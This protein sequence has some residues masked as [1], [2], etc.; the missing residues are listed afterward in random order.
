MDSYDSNTEKSSI[1]LEL[2]RM[3]L[4]LDDSEIIEPGQEVDE[5]SDTETGIIASMESRRYY[6]LANKIN[7]EIENLAKTLNNLSISE[8]IG[9]LGQEIVEKL[10]N[11]IPL[12]AVVRKAFWASINRDLGHRISSKINSVGI[13]KG[14]KIVRVSEKDEGPNILRR[15]LGL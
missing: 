9:V 1:F 8:Q 15:L 12:E 13:R 2:H 11:L 3:F 4:Q 10:E 14:W 6:S 5:D 7:K